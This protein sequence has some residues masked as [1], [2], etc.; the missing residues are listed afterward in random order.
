MVY[1]IGL[2]LP[3]DHVLNVI[4]EITDND[5]TI[6][7]LKSQSR[8]LNPLVSFYE[9]ASIRQGEIDTFCK[10]INQNSYM[11]AYTAVNVIVSDPDKKEVTRKANHVI[12]AFS[13]MNES[14]CYIETKETANLF[15]A[16]IPGNSSA[17]YRGFIN[18]VIQGICYLQKESLYRSDPEG[19]LFLDRFGT[20]C[21]LEMRK[22]AEIVNKNRILIGP[23][24]SGK[25]YWL[26]EFIL[27]SV[28]MKNDVVIIDIGG[29]YKSNVL[30]NNGKYYDSRDKRQFSFNP[31]LCQKDKNSNYIY[32]ND[33]SD[34]PE[35]QNDVIQYITTVIS[36]IWKP[37]K[38]GEQ[39]RAV[40]KELLKESIIKFYVYV[41]KNKIFPCMDSYC[42]FMENY[43]LD[44]MAKLKFD[45][46][47]LLLMLKEYRKEGQFGFLLNS[48]NNLDIT[49]DRLIAFDLEDAKG[50]DY[51]QIVIIIVLNLIADKIKKRKGITKE[52]IIDEAFDFLNDEKMG[53]FIAYLFRTFRK[54]E[55]EILIAAQ[56]VLF[57][58]SCPP[59]IKDSILINSDTKILLNHS[60]FTDNY[61]DIQNV[62]SISESEIEM[63]DSL[64]EDE[65]GR[66]FYIKM[67]KKSG[68][69]RL[70][71][72]PIA[73]IS[74]D[75]RQAKVIE[76]QKLRE[77]TG[78]IPAALNQM[79][80]NRRKEAKN[81]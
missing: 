73:D 7:K 67:G 36:V 32:I 5:S 80:E 59:Q 16:S 23:S 58:K 54:K 46:T 48:E 66:E 15:F 11:T 52:L 72:S 8:M 10:D 45:V 47:E 34:D 42:C 12:S 31:F 18:T 33:A 35:A 20:P 40:E 26:N 43:K 79:L 6:N 53:D 19:Y 21:L 25:S 1:P 22:T 14:K 78:S 4:I 62:L 28:E 37:Q 56:N 27:Q 41:N 69:F 77:E 50:A 81:G 38:S 2:G 57:I 61:K 24:G 75:S 55:G 17:N 13:N 71:V 49:S 30:L 3:F 9:P 63:L 64:Q 39:L 51:F 60:K 74:Y 44:E 76:L 65:R 68:I 70:E 29:S